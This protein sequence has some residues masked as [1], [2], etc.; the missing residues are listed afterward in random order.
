MN[1]FRLAIVTDVHGDVHALADALAQIG[2]LACDAIVCCGDVVD[3]GLFPDETIELLAR[4]KIPTVCGNHDRWAIEGSSATGGGW[5]LSKAS[6]KFL[7]SLP[8]EWRIEHAGIR[9]AVHHASPGNDMLGISPDEIDR[10]EADRHLVA[11]N[12]DVLVVGHTHRGFELLVGSGKRILNPAAL[13]RSPAEGATNPPATGTFGVLE[14]P[15]LR[16]RVLC[17]A[18]GADVAILRKTLG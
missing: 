5:D 8:T 16:F 15:L 14:L 7:A 1:V 18:D 12:A 11:A 6:R 9:V 2:R 10:V 4:R 17:A 13:L 3:Y